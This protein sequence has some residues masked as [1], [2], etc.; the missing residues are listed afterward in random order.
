MRGASSSRNWFR[1]AAWGRS[2]RSPKPLL[3]LASDDSSFATGADLF[4]DGGMAQL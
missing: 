3:F 1:S 2:T 4:A